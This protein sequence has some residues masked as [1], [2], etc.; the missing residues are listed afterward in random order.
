MD[1]NTHPTCSDA[2]VAIAGVG[3][4]CGHLVPAALE[5]DVCVEL[6]LADYR[7]RKRVLCS[8][9]LVSRILVD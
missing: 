2:N 5:M 6:T 7:F 8:G 4:D 9:L 1:Y 3:S